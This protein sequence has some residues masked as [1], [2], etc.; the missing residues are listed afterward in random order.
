MS[1]WQRDFVNHTCVDKHMR[2]PFSF[3]FG[4]RTFGGYFYYVDKFLMYEIFCTA[5][6]D[7]GELWRG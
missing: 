5:F 7:C 4:M 2:Y 3:S 6:A 1:C